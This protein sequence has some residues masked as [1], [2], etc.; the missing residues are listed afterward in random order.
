[1]CAKV[2]IFPSLLGSEK[3][4]EKV[5]TW[6]RSLRMNCVS[7]CDLENKEEHYSRVFPFQP[8]LYRAGENQS[9]WFAMRTSDPASSSY[10]G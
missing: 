8:I 6:R 7:C 1:L 5:K 2:F 9:V 10:F 3:I 4:V